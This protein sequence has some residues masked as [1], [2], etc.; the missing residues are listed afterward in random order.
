MNALRHPQHGDDDREFIIPFPSIFVPPADEISAATAHRTTSPVRSTKNGRK[1]KTAQRELFQ[2]VDDAG[3]AQAEALARQFSDVQMTADQAAEHARR[4][5]LAGYWQDVMRGEKAGRKRNTLGAY[6][7]ALGM[8]ERFAPGLDLPGWV[9]MPIGL[10]TTPYVQAFFTA[11]AKCV[12]P[13]TINSKWKHLAAIF[14]HAKRNGVIAR[15]PAPELLTVPTKKTAIFYDQQIADTYAA[16]AGNVPLQVAFVVAINAGLR[17]VDLFQLAWVN[18]DR[19]ARTLSFT[20][21]KT[22]KPQ[23]VP[24]AEITCRHIDRLHAWSGSS[25]YLFHSI[26]DPLS[27][28][29]ERSRRGRERNHEFKQL[30]K[31][32]G[33][34]FVKPWQA[35]RATCNERLE[36]VREGS[37]QFVLGHG[38]TLNSKSYREPSQLIVEAV[39]NVPQPLCFH[40]FN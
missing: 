39:D 24:L 21:T 28:D 30:L 1:S 22:G 18:Y 8:W 9:G 23:T 35:C 6:K 5:T 29:P 37:G 16:L 25:A 13:S 31:S 34:H 26:A 14:S 36:S 19:R 4:S 38:C 12:A 15:V 11:A 40:H 32:L 7:T 27:T 33:I 20:A 3:I 10:V 2:I 17:P